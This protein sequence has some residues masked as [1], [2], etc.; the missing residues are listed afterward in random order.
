MNKFRKVFAKITVMIFMLTSVLV[1]NFATSAAEKNEN[2]T[3]KSSTGKQEAGEKGAKIKKYY[4]KGEIIVKYRE[5]RNKETVRNRIKEKIKSKIARTSS[6]IPR[7]NKMLSEN[8]ELISVDINEDIEMMA[9]ELGK[10]SEVVYAQPNYIYHT[11]YTPQDARFSEQWSFKNTNTGIDINAVKAWD[12]TRG[13]N[14][15]VIAV[16]DSGV[17]INHPELNNNIYTN[18]REVPGNAID[19]DGN[20]YIDDVNGW[21]FHNNDN[22]VYD[23]PS[24]D[25]HGTHVAGTIAASANNVGVIG[26]APNV[27]IM[28]LKFINGDEGGTNADAIL[29]IN[30]AKKMGVTLANCSWGGYYLDTALQDAISNS[31]ILFICAAGNDCTD[32]AANPHSPASFELSNVVAVSAIDADGSLASFSNYGQCVDVAAP[33]VKILSTVPNNSYAFYNGTSMAAPH[34]TGIAA[35]IKS[36]YPGISIPEITQ[37]IKNSSMTFDSIK[38]MVPGGL[39]VDAYDAVKN[40]AVLNIRKSI[41]TENSVYFEWADVPN[42]ST[43]VVSNLNVVKYQ[44]TNTNFL[45]GGLQPDTSYIFNIAAKNS[46]G[47]VIAEKRILKKS[48]WAGKGNGLKASY[49]NDTNMSNL[50]LTRK[51]NVDFNW[52]SGSPDASIGS[53]AFSVKWQGELEAKYSEEYTF[54]A[55][56]QGA[57]KLWIDGKLIFDKSQD[58]SDTMQEVYGSISL[59]AG[60]YYPVQLEYYESMGD[61]S[62]KLLWSSVSQT[63]EAVPLNRLYPFIG[64]SGAWSKMNSTNSGQFAKTHVMVEN[65]QLYAVCEATNQQNISLYDEGQNTFVIKTNIPGSYKCNFSA[66]SV[67]GK[68]YLFGGWDPS[69]GRGLDTVQE[70]DISSG[71]WATKRP[72][73]IASY[74]NA[75]IAVN[76]KIYV[77][78]GQFNQN[79][80]LYDPSW[81]SWTTVTQMPDDIANIFNYALTQVDGKIYLTGGRYGKWDPVENIWT[82]TV[83]SSVYE[84]DTRNLIWTKKKDMPIAR[85]DHGS[86]ALDGKIFAIGGSPVFGRKISNVDM[87]DLESDTW[88]SRDNLL[89]PRCQM[90]VANLNGKIYALFGITSGMAGYNDADV[91]APRNAKS[92]GTPTPTPAPTA[93]STPT[94]TPTTVP[95]YTP[96]PTI[97]NIAQWSSD[98][99]YYA[100]GSLVTY[101]GKTYKC[102]FAHN[103]N[104]AWTPVA[105]L[106][107]LW[108]LN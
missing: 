72:L 94:P 97:G 15:V 98:N 71:S 52:G 105:T 39:V 102:I 26:V 95:T 54:Y 28:P 9:K 31:G 45:L 56:T 32:I 65:G 17:D 24:A 27:K 68:I 38:N 82:Q 33:G 16:I 80:Y 66:A 20:G 79:V 73:P 106:N 25:S 92:G 21:D 75:A 41:S 18:T 13:S 77:F 36:Q 40:T 62:V 104:I 63:K 44:G 76:N 47:Q 8:I 51:E 74:E 96:T 5:T 67:N 30:Y 14:S 101:E 78:G 1:P 83:L 29:A 23:S 87:Y 50:K 3:I 86:A 90:G 46:S 108:K 99:V 10:D 100:V 11:T 35:L 57:A 42:A 53:E 61:A 85:Y 7:S 69:V 49:Y 2:S 84:F 37:K 22:T 93:T 70:Y 64:L 19:D 55:Q 48:I 6:F 4:K 81:D 12:V 58:D 89:S 60:R 107:I 103:S 34:V 88:Y 43:Y 91:F 59:E